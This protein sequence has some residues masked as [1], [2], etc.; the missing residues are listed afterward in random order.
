[1]LRRVA[2]DIGAV[3]PSAALEA[4]TRATT[5]DPDLRVV[6]VGPGVDGLDPGPRVT[7]QA[8]AAPD[9]DADPA[10]AVRGRADL[11][12][13]VALEMGRD[14]AVDTVMSASPTAALLT[15]VRFLL[16]RRTGVRDPLLAVTLRTDAGDVVLLDASG[17][18]GSTPGSLAGAAEDLGSLPSMVGLLAPG[19]GDGRAAARLREATGVEVDP[20]GAA[21]VLAGRAPIV[22]ADGAA[23]CMLVDAVAALAPQRLGARRVVGLQDTLEV[24]CLG[25]DV[26]AWR[27]RGLGRVPEAA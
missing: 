2:L 10:V 3:D 25:D 4:A 12:V 16:R 18:G 19:T 9:A 5:H 20:I 11:S 21:A 23:G 8:A 7:V 26:A 6:V 22:F 14:G 15:A 1:M 27:E 24:L 17:R 13:R